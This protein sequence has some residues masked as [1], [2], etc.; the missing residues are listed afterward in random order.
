MDNKE[1]DVGLHYKN[2]LIVDDEP[3]ILDIFSQFLS[4]AGFDIQSALSN[5]EALNYAQQTVFDLIL[6]DVHMKGIGFSDF[7]AFL[8]RPK[9]NHSTVPIIAVTGIPD[10]I[11]EEDRVLLSGILEKP[12]TPEIML[13]CIQSVISV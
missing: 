6:L 10:A 8:K 11:L 13:S 7:I 2:I 5:D 4:D 3:F 1:N 12:F 9:G